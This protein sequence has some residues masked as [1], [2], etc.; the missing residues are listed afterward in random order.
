M[1]VLTPGEDKFDEVMNV[2][3]SRGSWDGG[4]Q[5]VL[6]EWRGS[7][8]HRLSFTYNTTPTAAYT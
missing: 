5:G 3:R 7:N 4:D 8:W 2:M 1:M 6:N